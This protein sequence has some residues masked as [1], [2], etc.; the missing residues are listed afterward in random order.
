MLRTKEPLGSD[1]MSGTSQT[2]IEIRGNVTCFVRSAVHGRLLYR[3][4]SKNLVVTTGLNLIRDLLGGIGLRP[5]KIAVGS[6]VAAVTA[7][8]VALGTETLKKLIDRRVRT[9]GAIE[10]QM[11]VLAGE[12]NGTTISEIGTFEEATLLARAVLSSPIVKTAAIEVT[13]SHL[14]TIAN[15]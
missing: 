10:Y 8:D 5:D 12:A 11:L 1:R 13:V 2:K 15:A 6:G 9:V 7:S 14:F 4:H 3:V